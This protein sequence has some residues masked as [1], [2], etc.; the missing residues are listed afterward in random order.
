MQSLWTGLTALTSAS[1]WLN[2]ISDNL[3]NTNTVGFASDEGSFA[4]TFTRA[5]QGT[6]TAPSVSGRYTPLGWWGGS[7]VM[8]VGGSN[9]FSKM[10]VATTGNPLDVSIA[11][12]GF[13]AVK[14]P[15]GTYLTKAGNFTWSQQADGSFALAMPNGLPVLDTN[16]QPITQPTGYTGI[17]IG[18]DG[19][20]TYGTTQG[21]KLAVLEVPNPS[22]S[23]QSVGD[24]LFAIK[25]TYQTF[26]STAS[27]VNQGS[28]LMS[29]VDLTTQ[30][31][32]MI[33]AQRM[34]DLNSE[35]ISMTN[36]MMGIANGLRG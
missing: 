36:K 11:G 10:P 25:P 16:G 12:P 8:N 3:A 9:D 29:N 26:Q 14:G 13:F 20:I 18:N 32:K 4:D 23:L 28:L 21:P 5:L 35:S 6:A 34:F 33:Q 7:G 15:S 30:M 22:A 19:Q 1:N 27:T 24:N 17:S 2:Q 31:T